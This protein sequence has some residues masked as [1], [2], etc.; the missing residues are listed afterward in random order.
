MALRDQIHILNIGDD[1]FEDK[2]SLLYKLI[3]QHKWSHKK[4]K[5]GRLAFEVAPN[6]VRYV[7]PLYKRVFDECKKIY[8][9]PIHEGRSKQG[10][11]CLVTNK[12]RNA[13]TW[14]SHEKT[15]WSYQPH[16][17]INKSINIFASSVYYFALPEGSGGIRFKNNIEEFE[18]IPKE[19]DLIF[20]PS[21][22]LHTPLTNTCTDWRVSYNINLVQT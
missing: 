12:Q 22:M 13:Y 18:Y 20:F 16:L 4:Y 3:L 8:D 17:T 7:E 11:F 21:D 14:H 2:E 10:S 19:G 15:K 1:F 5:S 6:N 9:N